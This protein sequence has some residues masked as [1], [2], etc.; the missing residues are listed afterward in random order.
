MKI[1]IYSKYESGKLANSKAVKKA[2]EQLAGK[3]IKITIEPKRKKRSN[4]QNRYYWGVLV[5][6]WQQLLKD[7]H[8]LIYSAQ[9]THEFLKANFNKVEI[10]NEDTGEFLTAPKSTTINTTTQM[11]EYHEKCRQVAF[12]FF[13]AVI[14]LPNEQIELNII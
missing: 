8:G 9:E 5:T 14:P 11:E 10:V 12:E 6:H 2:F 7:E 13:G 3:D 1:E 4:E